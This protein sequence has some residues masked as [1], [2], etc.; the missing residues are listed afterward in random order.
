MQKIAQYVLVAVL[1]S[2][3]LPYLVRPYATAE[4]KKPPGGAKNLT[5]KG[6]VMHMLVHHAQ[7]PT[8]S[9]LVVALIVGVS[10]Y[11]T[12]KYRLV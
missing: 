11:I 2:L 8:S 10:V 5:T 3:A 6:Q 1:L 9:S 7:V 12:D 4:E